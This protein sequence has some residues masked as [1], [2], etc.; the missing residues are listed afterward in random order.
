MRLGHFGYSLVLLALVGCGGTSGD[1]TV[2]GTDASS[3]QSAPAGVATLQFLDLMVLRP[4]MVSSGTALPT[5]VT[6]STPSAGMTRYAFA[7][8]PSANAGTLNGTI[9]IT[10]VAAGG[11]TTYTEAIHLTDVPKG[12]TTTSWVYDGVQQVAVA[13]SQA[14]YSLPTG[15]QPISLSYADSTNATNDRTYTYTPSPDPANLPLTLSWSGSGSAL[16]VTVT[17]K[18]LVAQTVPAS[19][20]K[21]LTSTISPAIVWTPACKYPTSGTLTLTISTSPSTATVDFNTGTCGQV[22][23]NGAKVTLGS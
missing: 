10:S 16:T 23:I 11:T 22:N 14:V 13:G 6:A 15:G 19:E 9:D 4:D 20:A 2:S 17:G 21:V 3:I 1:T 12:S 5:G 7:D 8:V 18:Y